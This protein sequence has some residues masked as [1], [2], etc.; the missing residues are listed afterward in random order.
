MNREAEARK[1]AGTK[2]NG[3]LEEG[4]R[5]TRLDTFPEIKEDER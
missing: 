2:K 5:P 1:R 3:A 4:G